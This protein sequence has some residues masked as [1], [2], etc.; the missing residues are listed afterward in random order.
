MAQAPRVASDHNRWVHRFSLLTAG[1]TFVLVV[2]GGLVTSTGSGLAVPDWPTT[3]GH[4]MFLY[5]WSK[6]VGGILIEHGHRLI[7]A[8][9]GLLTLVLALWLWVAERRASLRWLGAAALALV[10]VQG[11]LGGLRVMWLDRTLAV[12]HAALAQVFFALMAGVAFFTSREGSEASRKIAGADAGRLR[13]LA[14]L[15]TSVIY[16]QM[17]FGAVLRHTGTGIGVHLVCGAVV[18]IQVLCLAV[19]ILTGYPHEPRLVRSVALLSAL[20]VLQLLVGVAAYLEK[21]ASLGVG[22]SFHDLVALTTTHVAIGA[23]MLATGLVLT[24][25]AYRLV[26]PGVPAVG[27][28][29]IPSHSTA[30]SEA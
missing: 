4:N 6:M 5:P 11:I 17:I 10:I 15:T 12:V 7:G 1:A 27:G 22:L 29:F 21:F 9:V 14:L 20:L 13:T 25:R 18:A 26:A 3:F 16:L 19:L 2:A 23:L 28:E 30:G 24:L 8:G